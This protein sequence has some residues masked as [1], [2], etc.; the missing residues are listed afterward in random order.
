[1][2]AV[3]PERAAYEAFRRAFPTED[4]GPWELLPAEDRPG[5]RRIAEGAAGAAP[6]LAEA[7]AVI[8]GLRAMVARKQQAVGT[9]G[10]ERGL[11]PV[12]HEPTFTATEI[13]AVIGDPEGASRG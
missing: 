6:Q 12:W 10:R 3:S 13:L 2:T 8:N 11:G 4:W 9:A 1:M 5:W 7:L